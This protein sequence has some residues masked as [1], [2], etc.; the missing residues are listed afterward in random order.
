[1]LRAMDRAGVVFRRASAVLVLTVFV[2]LSACGGGGTNAGDLTGPSESVSGGDEQLPPSDPEEWKA[3]FDDAM[4]DWQSAWASY[5]ARYSA[6]DNKLNRWTPAAGPI[7][8]ALAEATVGID[9]TL[10]RLMVMEDRYE[11]LLPLVDVALDNDGIPEVSSGQVSETDVRR[12]F[13]VMG[14]YIDAS[15]RGASGVQG[16]LFP[17][18]RGRNPLFAEIPRQSRGEGL[19]GDLRRVGQA[20][21]Q[22][23]RAAPESDLTAPP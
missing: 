18:G 6:F 1:M 11:K 7:E 8:D 9:R 10:H 22:A 12:Y 16:V 17:G 20:S 5:V 13:E 4:A 14:D 2:A 15:R 3:Q 19:P 21:V 23:L